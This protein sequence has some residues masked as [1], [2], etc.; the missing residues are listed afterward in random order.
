ML[1][2][3]IILDLPYWVGAGGNMDRYMSSVHGL[4]QL[5]SLVASQKFFQGKIQLIRVNV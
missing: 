3:V 5:N 2:Y 1:S 4:I